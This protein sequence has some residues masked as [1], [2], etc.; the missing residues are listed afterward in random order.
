MTTEALTAEIGRAATALD[1]AAATV[2]EKRATLDASVADAEAARDLADGHANRSEAA[3][4]LSQG[5][6]ATAAAQAANAA[7]NS[8]GQNLAGMVSQALPM[9]VLG[10]H[11]PEP[12]GYAPWSMGNGKSWGAEVRTTGTYRGTA[13]NATA[14]WAISGAASGDYVYDTTGAVFREL[15]TSN[16]WTTT[17]RAGTKHMPPYRAVS[18]EAAR[19]I[20]WDISG[21]TPTMWKVLK[22][23]DVALTSVAAFGSI[24]AI[25]STVTGLVIWDFASETL[26][27]YLSSGRQAQPWT[28]DVVGANFVTQD[29]ANGIVNNTASA[30]AITTLPDAP[31]DAWGNKVPTIPVGTNGGLSVITHNETVY[32]SAS[33]TAVVAVTATPEGVWW[34][35]ATTLLFATWA[36]VYAGD[37]FGDVVGSTTAGAEE[38][39]LYTVP[40][41]IRAAGN[42]IIVAGASGEQV[43]IPDYND[44]NNSASHVRNKDYATGIMFG[45]IRGAF[46]ASDN[47]TDLVG[48]TLLSDDFS[49]YADTA[50]VIAAGWDKR[51][52]TT[53]TVALV[54]SELQFTRSGVAELSSAVSKEI[55]GFVVG[56][57]YCLE[58]E[59]RVVS[60]T[61]CLLALRSNSGGGGEQLAVILSTVEN[62]LQKGRTYWKADRTSAYFSLGGTQPSDSVAGTNFRITKA[63]PDRSVKGKG[64]IINGTIT[65]TQEAN[66]D[67]IWYSG[68]SASNYLE[69]PYNSDLNFGTG[70]FTL[71]CWAYLAGTNIQNLFF[72]TDKAGTGFG[73]NGTIG[74]R[75]NSGWQWSCATA[76]AQSSEVA[77]AGLPVL[78]ALVRRSGMLF[79]YIGAKLVAQVA[80]TASLGATNTSSVLFIGGGFFNGAYSGGF[81]GGLALLRASGTAETPEQIAESARI[82]DAM[83]RGYFKLGG[84]SNAILRIAYAWKT[85]QLF[86]LTSSGVSTFDMDSWQ[87][88]ACAAGSWTKLAAGPNGELWLG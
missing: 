18:F 38:I 8:A 55:T 81:A 57:T 29:A 36:D 68:W 33:T 69:Q 72:I 84:S 21:Q 41:N 64:L 17:N 14:A 86:V 20:I 49:G 79:A 80:N 76:N 45:D 37:G 50:A 12:L 7:A 25:T 3:R 22:I 58:G 70:D 67:L 26:T 56:E 59:G 51:D 82:E 1:N 78:A 61:G 44:L 71:K 48:S 62:T 66:S 35:T 13:A 9:T 74:L 16:A 85:R 30:V 75:Y 15:T 4:D 39:D 77:I 27:R 87:R 11:I 23:N 28:S 65:K 54:G 53:G 40:T 19:V 32:D 24:V 88:V 73:N 60:G 31:L 52:G 47:D 10:L 42:Q 5:Y 34:S 43:I 63:S 2:L 6:A 46:L 83:R